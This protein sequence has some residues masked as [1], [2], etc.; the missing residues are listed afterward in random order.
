MSAVRLLANLAAP[1]HAGSITPLLYAGP[2]HTR[3]NPWAVEA[4]FHT[5]LHAGLHAGLHVLFH[6]G[7]HAGLHA[8]F[9][10]LSLAAATHFTAAARGA[11]HLASAAPYSSAAPSSSAATFGAA[12]AA[13]F[14]STSAPAAA[15]TRVVL[16][17]LE[18]FGGRDHRGAQNGCRA[19]ESQ[20][21]R[22]RP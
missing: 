8:L 7:P 16:R 15:L 22:D 17:D 14:A 11:A 5:P 21:Q 3:F 6:A 10:A 9:H 20:S 2:V 13:S 1:L 12:T 19:Y 18:W 4:L